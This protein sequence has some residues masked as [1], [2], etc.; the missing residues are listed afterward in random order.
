MGLRPLPSDV[1]PAAHLL[2]QHVVPGNTL[3]PCAR[4]NCQTRKRLA[5]HSSR[6]L[7]A[8][9]IC[10]TLRVWRFAVRG[11]RRVRLPVHCFGNA[12]EGR[13]KGPD[14]CTDGKSLV[15]SRRV[16]FIRSPPNDPPNALRHRCHHRSPTPSLCFGAGMTAERGRRP[17]AKRGPSPRLHFDFYSDII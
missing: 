2:A 11:L 4:R 1:I 16:R 13:W 3:S 14:K 6:H 17:G 12:G 10:Q 9:H 5:I 7:G 15:V 8:K